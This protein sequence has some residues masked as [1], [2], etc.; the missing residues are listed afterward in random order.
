MTDRECHKMHDLTESPSQPCDVDTVKL[1]ILQVG[2]SRHRE[3]NSFAQD[4]IT[5]IWQSWDRKPGPCVQRV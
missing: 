3:V 4:H 2:E 1:S 5:S